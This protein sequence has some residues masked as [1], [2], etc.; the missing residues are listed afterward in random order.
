MNKTLKTTL[1][2]LLAVLIGGAAYYMSTNK[3]LLKGSILD[4]ANE[5]YIVAVEFADPSPQVAPVN[6]VVTINSL[7]VD[8][9]TLAEGLGYVDGELDGGD[10]ASSFV[11]IQCLDSVQCSTDGVSIT[12]N[13]ITVP[14]GTA[15]FH[16][17]ISLASNPGAHV[18]GATLEILSPSDCSGLQ[19]ILI[20]GTGTGI[21][22]G[23]P[24]NLPEPGY[25]LPNGGIL[26]FSDD[27]ET[28]VFNRNI[29]SDPAAKIFQI[30]INLDETL[31]DDAEI[32]YSSGTGD[33]EI[34]VREDVADQSETAENFAYVFNDLLGLD[35][36]F[37]ASLYGG[38][39]I[40]LITKELGA[41]VNTEYLC[42]IDDIFQI[43]CFT[44]GSNAS[45]PD[46]EGILT[47]PLALDSTMTEGD[48]GTI[49]LSGGVGVIEWN[50][51]DPSV[52]EV[53]SLSEAEE[54]A[55][56]AVQLAPQTYDAGVLCGGTAAYSVDECF[57]EWSDDPT[58][59]LINNSCE[60]SVTLPLDC[61]APTDGI[62]VVD[63]GTDDVDI[64]IEYDQLSGVLYGSGTWNFEQTSMSV[65]FDDSEIVG[66]FTGTASGD[67]TGSL[68]GSVS[69]PLE[70][71][72]GNITAIPVLQ[73]I[74]ESALLAASITSPL[75]S[76]LLELGE[77]VNTVQLVD[78]S[79]TNYAYAYA[80]R[81]GESTLT[82][83]DSNS[84]VVVL[85]I[86][87]LGMTV[88]L[89][90]DDY[91][92][93]EY[94]QV[95]D[96]IQINAFLGNTMGEV[97]E[98]QNVTAE[99]GIEWFSSDETVATVDS[100]GILTAIGAGNTNVT[101]QYDTGEAEIG[102]VESEIFS[103][104]VDEI[105]GLT[106]SLDEATQDEL[107][108]EEI[109]AGYESVLLIVHNSDVTG[110][111]LTVEGYDIDIELPSGTYVNDLAEV[112][113]ITTGPI[114]SVQLKIESE[115][116][117]ASGL[118]LVQVSTVPGYPG[119]LVLEPDSDDE[120]GMVDI[121]TTA[122]TDD[123]TIVPNFGSGI[124]LPP[125]ET[126]ALMVIAEYTS[127]KT[128]RLNP[129]DVTWVNTPVNYLEQSSLDT[130]LLEFGE[131]SGTST[132]VAQFT[133]PDS[134]V[135]TSNTLYITV[136]SGPVIDYLY[137]IGVGSITEGSQ[138][139]LE[140]KV[141][142][143]DSIADIQDINI[144]IVDADDPLVIFDSTAFTDILDIVV[145][146]EG[147]EG[148]SAA[149][150]YRI[151]T[152]PVQIPESASLYDGNY[153]I[154]ITVTDTNSHS[155]G[156]DLPIYIGEV[157]SGDVNGDGDL[158]MVDVIYLFQIASG[159]ITGT[160]SQLEASDVNGD[161]NIT[162]VDVIIL[163]QTIAS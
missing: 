162:M 153:Y 124:D 19:A 30:I 126:Y 132:V 152:I 15:P 158:N 14:T 103:V 73:T 8:F 62:A 128:E 138:V 41:Q 61:A 63:F 85:D 44:G 113:A 117:V 39:L 157:A 81:E 91:T 111:T 17:I 12:G 151:Y 112:E 65:T 136:A 58:P 34:S 10:I 2:I 35:S 97:F 93:G 33:Y 123:L 105:T 77:V 24:A 159:T 125:E 25:S 50:S 54:A 119:I 13:E 76:G 121:S 137:R 110:H 87:V 9:T 129:T 3:Q 114:D 32:T 102:T 51:F 131:I 127:G 146:E 115:V 79:I 118:D 145:E 20:E 95:D 45:S 155:Y 70:N 5:S 130:G 99:A 38:G 68:Y 106:I 90:S 42:T 134:S 84:C 98:D 69:L 156:Y 66:D 21:Y 86:D 141:S 80:K 60:V 163:F 22:T 101:A 4:G 148:E 120:N 36:P 72:S 64:D 43:P 67:A 37:Y 56:G 135:A 11:I 40:G 88:E 26:D 139:E 53:V 74:T 143:V 16:L 29:A 140:M 154:S 27:L 133:N 82:I 122:N 57:E 7:W 94:L 55:E 160:A 144:K 48:S 89:S 150:Y 83:T 100:T 78:D 71:I 18:N 161:G 52:L 109:E 46:A 28:I 47:Q 116:N 104:T 149:P 31:V 147:D 108:A 75:D 96:Q 23:D 107:T 6:N 92:Q 1:L 142:D 49:Y 59:V